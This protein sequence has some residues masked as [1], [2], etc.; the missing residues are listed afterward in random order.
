M[1][2]LFRNETTVETIT[3]MAGFASDE[4]RKRS[5]LVMIATAVMVAVAVAMVIFM[6]R[7]FKIV[8]ILLGGAIIAVTVI[9]FWIGSSK[10]RNRDSK[11]SSA[12][13]IRTGDT[14]TYIYEFTE[15]T[16]T[17]S[18]DGEK[19]TFDLTEIQSARDIGAAFQLRT[20]ANNYTVKKSGFA[21]EDI[22][23]FRDLMIYKGIPIK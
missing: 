16:V 18:I 8:G 22:K 14:R 7:S 19:E 15:E 1:D 11:L 21:K 6:P 5:K 10:S 3:P 17:V 4:R 20:A 13:F 12:G 2:I 23:R 9:E